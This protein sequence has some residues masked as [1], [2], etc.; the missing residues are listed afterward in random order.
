MQ[1]DPERIRVERDRGAWNATYG[2]LC[3]SYRSMDNFG[4]HLAR[5]TADDVQ[6]IWRRRRSL[7]SWR[8]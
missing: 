7:G 8:N 6:Y 3:V 5:I 4:F 2:T 1:I